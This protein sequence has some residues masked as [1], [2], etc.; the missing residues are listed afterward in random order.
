MQAPQQKTC[1]AITFLEAILKLNFHQQFNAMSQLEQPKYLK[2]FLK[3]ETK[4]KILKKNLQ[5]LG[6]NQH[7]DVEQKL[8]VAVNKGKAIPNFC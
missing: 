8:K 4:F 7:K 2:N 1:Y 6:T 3:N 5:Y